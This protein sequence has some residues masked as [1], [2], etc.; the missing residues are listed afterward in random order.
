M[1]FDKYKRRIKSVLN[2]FSFLLLISLLASCAKNQINREA[3]FKRVSFED[4]SGWSKDHHLDAF[5]SFIKSCDAIMRRKSE[6]PISGLTKIGGK[7]AEWQQICVAALTSEVESD[8]EAKDFFE[9]WFAV[10]SIHDGN[11]KNTGRMTGYYEI[12]LQGSKKQTKQYKYPIYRAPPD[13]EKLK[14]CNGFCHASINRG[15]LK[16]KKLEIVWVDSKARA[17]FLHIQGSGIVKL[18]NGEEVKLGYAC[19]NGFPY[20][21]VGSTLKKYGINQPCSATEIMEWLDKNPKQ[22]LRIMEENKSYVF[23]REIYGESPL[24]AQG[25]PLKGE[26]SI[27]IDAKLYPYGAPF[28]L[29]TK[30]PNTKYSN[31]STPYNRLMIAQD[32]GG[33]IKGAI[34]ADIFFGRGKKAETLASG[35]SSIG[36]YYILL[37]KSVPVP[38]IQKAS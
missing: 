36:K 10:Y 22:G 32:T 38:I 12:E 23:F 31:S 17:F 18:P 26:R 16:N 9:K 19:Q 11:G 25:I 35:T 5:Q 3:H 7:S 13:I 29:E 27:A 2:F 28:W 34:R 30:L 20:T 24:G 21:A 14:G 1:V 6:D 33:A 15:A 37:P 8:H 4:L